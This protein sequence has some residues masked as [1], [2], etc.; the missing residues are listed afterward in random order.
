MPRRCP[1]CGGT[2]VV[3]CA[4]CNGN[5]CNWCDGEGPCT[6]PNCGGYGWL[7]LDD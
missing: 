3:Y 1:S 2:G 5:G 7:D 4:Y 6:C